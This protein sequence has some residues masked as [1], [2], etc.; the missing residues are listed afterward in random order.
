MKGG[1][2]RGKK[3]GFD[4][5]CFYGKTTKRALQKKKK[6][7]VTCRFTTA[8]RP[9]ETLFLLLFLCCLLLCVK[10]EFFFFSF[11]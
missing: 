9:F 7:K 4:F 5:V 8:S 2:E 10:C 11:V 6:E 1:G 3:K